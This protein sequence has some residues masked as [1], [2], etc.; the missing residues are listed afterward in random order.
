M[1]ERA[2]HRDERLLDRAERRAAPTPPVAGDRER[3]TKRAP[4]DV[5]AAGD[6]HGG[7]DA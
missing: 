6:D 5:G 3:S 4:A 1:S 7:R 2:A